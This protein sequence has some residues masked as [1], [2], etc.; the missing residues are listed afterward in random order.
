MTQ[1]FVVQF[2]PVAVH[3]GPLQVHWYGLMYLLGFLGGWL[4]GE[5]RRKR[6]CGLVHSPRQSARHVA[7]TA[8]HRK[9]LAF[10][11]LRVVDGS[12]SSWNG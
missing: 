9:A 3:L 11:G 2:S 6:G 7:H 8:S 4:L 12:L 5:Y 1:P 10:A